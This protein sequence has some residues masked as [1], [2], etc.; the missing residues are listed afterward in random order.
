MA[1]GTGPYM[2]ATIPGKDDP[3]LKL[4]E[5]VYASQVYC[6]SIL[7]RFYYLSGY[8]DDLTSLNREVMEGKTL[9]RVIPGISLLMGGFLKLGI[10]LLIGI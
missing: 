2:L 4:K 6:I 7:S 1:I 9:N 5:L 10:S 8:R 3:H